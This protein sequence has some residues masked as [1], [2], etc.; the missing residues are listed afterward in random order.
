V[1][2]GYGN[3]SSESWIKPA[4]FASGDSVLLSFA[5][6]GALIRSYD[7][8][9]GAMISNGPKE[10]N[11]S[12][13]VTA[14]APFITP[15]GAPRLLAASQGPYNAGLSVWD[16][17]AG[18]ALHDIKN[19]KSSADGHAERGYMWAWSQNPIIVHTATGPSECQARSRVRPA[20]SDV[21]H[22]RPK[23][24]YGL[25]PGGDARGPPRG[26]LGACGR[27]HSGTHERRRMMSTLTSS[28]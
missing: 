7:A 10:Y 27:G 3:V 8:R 21:Y 19:G 28:D 2:V 5:Y 18:E 6:L 12:W 16:P 26:C 9:T 1:E 15:S 20:E 13:K 24:Q 14:L 17:T 23:G 4:F 22:R 11:M 25:A